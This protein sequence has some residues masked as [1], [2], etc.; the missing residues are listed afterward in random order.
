MVGINQATSQEILENLKTVDKIS[1]IGEC[2]ALLSIHWAIVLR[3]VDRCSDLHL[4][5][6]LDLTTIAAT[7]FMQLDIAERATRPST[8]EWAFVDSKVVAIQVKIAADFE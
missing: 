1:F 2:W 4:D 3:E 5:S 6:N 7:P 8:D